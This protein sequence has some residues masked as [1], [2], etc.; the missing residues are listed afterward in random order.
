MYW[1]S[2]N[3]FDDIEFLIEHPGANGRYTEFT[4]VLRAVPTNKIGP[5]VGADFGVLKFRDW[6]GDGVHE[7]IIETDVPFLADGEYYYA[8]RTVLKY[9]LDRSGLPIL[10]VLQNEEIKEAYSESW[11]AIYGNKP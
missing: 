3:P 5:T 2:R 7:A 11:K 8:Q 6:D 4:P 1:D 9:T 10:L